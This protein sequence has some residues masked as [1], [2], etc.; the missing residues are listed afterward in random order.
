M[1]YCLHCLN[2][3]NEPELLPNDFDQD[4]VYEEAPTYDF[5]CYDCDSE[6]IRY[7]EEFRLLHVAIV[8]TTFNLQGDLIIK[9]MNCDV[10]LKELQINVNKFEPEFITLNTIIKNL[11]NFGKII[12]THQSNQEQALTYHK[13]NPDALAFVPITKKTINK[14]LYQLNKPNSSEANLNYHP[15]STKEKSK[16]QTCYFKFTYRNSPSIKP[17]AYSKYS[18][19]NYKKKKKG[20]Y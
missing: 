6:F 2:K 4:E 12:F 7:I 18:L 8:I 1:E 11:R 20:A 19:I 10:L 17:C 13:L 14:T 5:L 16:V 9:D 15:V 3:R